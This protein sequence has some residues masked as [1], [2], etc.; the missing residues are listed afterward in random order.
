[1]RIKK[2][3]FCLFVLFLAGL[4]ILSGCNNENSD[5]NIKSEKGLSE[6]RYLENQCINIFNKY[7]SDEYVLE[8]GRIDWDLINNEFEVVRNSIDVILIDFASIQVSSKSIVEL[9][10]YFRDLDGFI[11]NKDIDGFMKKICDSYVL[12]S[13]SILNNLSNDEQI[14]LEKRLKGNLLYIGYYLMNGNKNE[15]INNLN[16][17]QQNYS[18]LS[19]E[20]EYIENNSYKI[21]RIYM[22]IQKLDKE[23]KS[24]NF[25]ESKK[26]LVEILDF[27]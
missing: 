3:K 27:F 14:I 18:R 9:E 1:M 25:E 6:I 5:E 4:F 21:N 11:Q 19:S 13:N 15:A 23:L 20:N 8:D 24:D 12:V 2:N 7:I 10:D 17:F 22:N 16:E 26:I